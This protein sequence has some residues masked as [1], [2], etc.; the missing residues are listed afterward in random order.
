MDVQHRLAHYVCIKCKVNGKFLFIS[1]CMIDGK[2]ARGACWSETAAADPCKSQPT[3]VNIRS[4][5]I[6]AVHS[7]Q[8]SITNC[9]GGSDAEAYATSG[10]QL[11][12]AGLLTDIGEPVLLN[13]IQTD[14][15]GATTYL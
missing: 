10:G 5:Q 2:G 3:L 6:V 15:P 9:D 12:Q 13:L 11:K 4:S 7:R 14:G 1:Y 8:A